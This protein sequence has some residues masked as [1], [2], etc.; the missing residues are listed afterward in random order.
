MFSAPRALSLV[1]SAAALLVLAACGSSD[2]D[3]ADTVGTGSTIE[4]PTTRRRHRVVWMW[5]ASSRAR[6]P[7][8]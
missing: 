3:S 8:K 7:R 1:V 4:S 2:P 6:S 5:G